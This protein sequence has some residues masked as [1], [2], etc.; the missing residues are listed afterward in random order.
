MGALAGR[1]HPNPF[2]PS[3]TIAYERA[4][5]GTTRLAIHDLGGRLVRELVA[6]TYV[7]RLEADGQV[8]VV[9]LTLVK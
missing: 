4:R 5:A 8:A 6:G 1:R 3:T 2:N 9:R 7:G